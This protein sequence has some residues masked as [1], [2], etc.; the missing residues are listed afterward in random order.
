MHIRCRQLYE[1]ISEL[2]R[3]HLIESGK[4]RQH[5]RRIQIFGFVILPI[6]NLYMKRALQRE[7][8]WL[9]TIVPDIPEDY[10]AKMAVFSSRSL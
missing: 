9:T 5:V 6:F 10:A 8:H 7:R 4:G 1:H 2:V 3:I